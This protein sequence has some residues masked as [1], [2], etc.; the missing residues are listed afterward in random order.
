LDI[1]FIINRGDSLERNEPDIS[2][3]IEVQFQD[4][5]IGKAVLLGEIPEGFPIETA[6][7]LVG[8]KPNETGSVLQALV[9]VRTGKPIPHS[10]Q[11]MRQ[12]LGVRYQ[13]VYQK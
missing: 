12:F 2:I 11:D 3:G 1:P 5:V 9:Y 6:D 4:F 7:A 13:V 8:A 10:V